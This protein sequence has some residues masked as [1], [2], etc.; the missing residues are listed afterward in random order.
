MKIP[1]QPIK[2][3]QGDPRWSLLSPFASYAPVVVLSL[4]VICMVQIALGAYWIA[5]MPGELSLY[6]SQSSGSLF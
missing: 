3:L 6:V 4:F 2:A 1:R 5:S